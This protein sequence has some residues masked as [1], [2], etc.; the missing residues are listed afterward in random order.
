MINTCPLKMLF[1]QQKNRLLQ[2]LMPSV[3][4][5]YFY[6]QNVVIHVRDASHPDY[7]LQGSTVTQTLTSLPLPEETPVITVANKIDLETAKP[8]E[9][10]KGAHLVSAL[11]GQ[12]KAMYAFTGNL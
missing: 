11:K 9:K 6:H 10:L 8:K 1:F 2:L 5:R 12:G 3:V 4:I 7:E